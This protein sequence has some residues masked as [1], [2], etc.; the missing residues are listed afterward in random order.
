MKYSVFWCGLLLMLFFIVPSSGADLRNDATPYTAAINTAENLSVTW[1][2]LADDYEFANRGLLVHVDPV[3]IRNEN[4]AEVINTTS[5]SFLNHNESP[6]T[7]QNS[8]YQHAQLNGMRGLFQ[9]TD[10]VYQVRGFDIA[11]MSFI[12]GDTGWIII[13]PLSSVETAKAAYDLVNET[14]GAYPVKAVI[15][16]HSHVDHYQGVKGVA[17]DAAVAAGDI[18]IIAPEGFMDHAVSENIYAGSAMQRRAMYMY[19]ATLPVDE[20]GYVDSG[21]G[22]TSSFGGSSSLITPTID[23]RKTGER[24]TIDGVVMEFQITPGTEAPAEMNVWFPE[25]KALCLAENCVGTFHN[26]LTIRGAQVRDPLAWSN[27]LDEALR[28]YGSDAE[29]LFTSHNWPRFG[30]GNVTSVIENQRDM[31]KYVHDQALHLMNQGYTMDEISHM[32]TL[33]DSLRRYGYTHEFYG[34]VQMAVKA[35]Y[36]KYLGFYDGNPTHLYNPDP[37]GFA[38]KMVE[39]MGGADAAIPKLREDYAA[40]NYQEVAT[41]AGYLVFADPANYEARYL[42]ADALEQLGYQSVSGPYRNAYLSAAQD[43]RASTS[44]TEAF[45]RNPAKTSLGSAD[46]MNA[47][48][49]DQ[50]CQYLAIQLNASKADNAELSIYLNMTSPE[51]PWGGLLQVQNSVL[52]AWEGVPGSDADAVISGNKSDFVTY[53]AQGEYSLEGLKQIAAISGDAGAVDRFM[54]MLEPFA[55]NFNIILP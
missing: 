32:I 20:K 7:I 47:L 55:P 19:G 45:L 14:L 13:D 22:T 16:T 37:T 9:V 23:I 46:V 53:L 15:Y 24:L 18:A 2:N 17:S 33:P 44:E 43:L 11:V 51:G 52:H 41:I 34:T 31:Y 30:N 25:K 42:Q 26:I 39:Y 12:K 54:G 8:L 28:L 10:S 40:G 21:L 49:F 29:V 3:I 35:V 1:Q 6:V 27:Y 4:G 48:S 38:V 5:F 50:I 36:Q